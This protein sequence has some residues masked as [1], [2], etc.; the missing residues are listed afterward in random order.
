MKF[1]IITATYNNDLSRLSEALS[2]QSFK[3]FEWIITDDGSKDFKAPK[4]PHKYIRQMDW[5]MRLAK[6]INKG[7]KIAKGEY[8]V[9]IMGDSFPDENYLAVLNN[10]ASPENVLCG[11]RVNVEKGKIIEMDWRLRKGL[12]PM[13]P[14]LLTDNEP[15]NLITGNGLVVP[16]EAFKHG[17][18]NPKFKGYGGEDNEL[19]ARLFFKGYLLW[20][21]PAVLYHEFHFGTKSVNNNLASKLIAS[22]AN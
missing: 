10:F 8:C 13:T 18:W 9:F 16:T 7:I 2:K 11:I 19:A 5:G 6:A 4:F 1:S 12:I 3:D 17:G 15:W 14:V 22:Y 21:I 20:S